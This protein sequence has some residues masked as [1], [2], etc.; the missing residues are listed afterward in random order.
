MT[1]IA[2]RDG[3]LAADSRVTADGWIPPYRDHKIEKLPDGRLLGFSGNPYFLDEFRRW[4]VNDETFRMPDLKDEAK[5]LVVSLDGNVT[6]YQFTGRFEVSAPFVAVG[7]GFP[8]ALAAMYAGADAK[9]A[10]EIA[11]LLDD[12]TGG[13]IDVLFLNK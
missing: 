2:Y 3:M 8:A 1:T 10:V 12:N 6:L 11:A 7:S 4:L 13:E 9:R 5:A